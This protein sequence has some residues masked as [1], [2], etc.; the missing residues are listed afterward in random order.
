MRVI[1]EID[2]RDKY[3]K[4]PFVSFTLPEGCRMTPAATQFLSDRKIEIIYGQ[5]VEKDIKANHVM[6]VA[7][8]NPNTGS[9]KPEYMTHLRGMELVPKSHP[10]IKFRGKLD[11]FEALLITAIL[12]AE[13]TGYQ[14]LSR[15][16]TELLDYARQ[17]MRADVIGEPLSQLKIRGWAPQEI[18][19]RSHYLRKYYDLD[20]FVPE[21]RHGRLLAQLNY[22][23]TQARE[24]ELAAIDI[25]YRDEKVVRE[26]ILQAVNRFSSLI[27]IFMAQLLSGDYKIG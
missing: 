10:G 21:P 9:K 18:R 16:L 3:K 19:E 26:D 24:L 2:L 20:H 25:F 23:R 7:T 13:S 27:Y 14:E 8:S 22:I 5:E 11:T 6:Q 12:D 15:D 4:V 1:T 17:M